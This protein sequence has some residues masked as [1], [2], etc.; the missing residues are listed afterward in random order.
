MRGARTGVGEE[1]S[2]NDVYGVFKNTVM[3]V[4]KGE[5][6]EKKRERMVDK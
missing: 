3:E 4:A 6:G 1:M 2:V 5:K